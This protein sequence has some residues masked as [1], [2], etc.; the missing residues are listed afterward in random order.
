M[1]WADEPMEEE[2]KIESPLA[3][4][5]DA[6]A[7]SSDKKDEVC[8]TE[9]NEWDK[10]LRVRWGLIVSILLIIYWWFVSCTSFVPFAVGA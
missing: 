8:G 9:E 5:D 10:L 3:L 2:G 6:S 4:T 7:P 1:E